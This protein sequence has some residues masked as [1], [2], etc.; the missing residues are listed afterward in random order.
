MVG[1]KLCLVSSSG[2]HLFH[3]N[4]L[5]PFW[6][7]YDRVWVASKKEDALNILKDETV[8]W[9]Y[10]PTPRNLK[11]LIRNSFLAWRVLRRE[12]P[13]VIVS[14]GSAVA[15]PFF[16]IGKLLVYVL[17]EIEQLPRMGPVV[18]LLGPDRALKAR[19]QLAA[20]IGDPQPQEPAPSTVAALEKNGGGITPGWTS[21]LCQLM[22]SLW[23]RGGVPVFR[24]PSLKPSVSRDRLN[25]LAGFSPTLPPPKLCLPI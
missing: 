5:R 6:S 18:Y 24:R 1:M 3:M 15:V 12:R 7:K 21:I 9:A 8:Y 11:N 19:D 20:D 2:G 14:A 16:Y 17:F 23:R 13:D 10:Y 22:L 4:L 25:S